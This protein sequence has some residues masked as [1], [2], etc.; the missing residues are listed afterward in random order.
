MTP[1]G[2]GPDVAVGQPSAGTIRPDPL[3]GGDAAGAGAFTTSLRAGA[4]LTTIAQVVIA[5]ASAIL[6]VVVARLLGP[7]GNGSFNVAVS[8][9]L[10]L[11][12]FCNAG[13][14]QGVNYL[15]GGGRW[16]GGDALRQAQVAA[17]ALGTAGAVVGV[18]VAAAAHGGIFRGA[19]LPVFA[20]A[21]AALPFWLSLSYSASVALARGRYAVYTTAVVALASA[22]LVLVAVLGS[23]FGLIGATA[24]FAAAQAVAAIGL[25]VW[26]T[27]RFPPRQRLRSS[28]TLSKLTRAI[29]FGS[30]PY[31]ADAL[32]FLN[33]RADLFIL[34]AV[35]SREAVGRYS[36]AVSVMTLGL[37]LPTALGTALLP[38]VAALGAF[39]S[40][41]DQ[42]AVI[43]KSLRH[44]V[45]VVPA[46]AVVL[47]AALA[48]VPLVYGRGFEPSVALGFILLPGTLA[49]GL[50][51]V[52][53]SIIVGKGRAT[54]P[55]YAT[56]IVTPPT[57]AAYLVLVPVMH[58]AGAALA[59]TL[60][61][62]TLTAVLVVFF[63]RAT[64]VGHLSELLPG[65]SELGD[66]RKLAAAAVGRLRA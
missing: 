30:K 38:R 14:P 46:T 48:V 66:Y 2:D 27:R 18:S 36:V 22:T 47:S 12:A 3:S 52:M 1:R 24:G 16:H 55:L 34:N 7:A 35:A 64:N 6:A 33:L 37:L 56:A 43:K 51:S 53:T 54:Y 50:G 40:T 63:R 17:L 49:Y 11:G 59:S 8:M 25:L 4:T 41:G 20:T 5:A 31:L 15:V 61:Y 28:E 62:V 29:R 23:V 19:S 58:A 10:L 39:S 45:L 42:L 65:R 60:S 13:I 57:L 26:G 21:A 9:L 32:Q 44:A